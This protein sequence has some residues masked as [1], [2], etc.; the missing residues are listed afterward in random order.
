MNHQPTHEPIAED[1]STETLL[2]GSR[3]DL[4]GWFL[5][6]QSASPQAACVM[7]HGLGEHAGRYRRLG[8]YLAGRRIACLAFDQQGH[9]DAPGK[10]G[11]PRS[12]DS[13]LEDIDQARQALRARVGD[14]PQFLLGHSMGGN[15]VTNYVLRWPHNVAGLV[16]VAPM[17]LPKNPPKRDQ[18]FA[19]W[20]TG[21]LLPFLRLQAN[22]APHELTHDVEEV[23]RLLSDRQLHHKMSMRLGTQLLAQGRWALDHAREIQIPVLA[24]HGEE[25][26]LTDYQASQSL[27]VRIGAHATYVPYPGLYH[28][29]LYETG[30]REVFA[31]I[32]SWM[33]AQ[34]H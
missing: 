16:L 20:L 3:S 4:P 17:L 10:R 13:M 18:I 34:V 28:G 25:D 9:G 5:C 14:V 6:S 22:T 1:L 26:T 15:L 8:E 31:E 29:L 12:Y 24:L 32:E 30:R 27:C 11:A 7:V 21:R 23:E 33:H 19:A 2:T